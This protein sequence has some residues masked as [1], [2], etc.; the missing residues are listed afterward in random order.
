MPDLV[1]LGINERNKYEIILFVLI[2]LYLYDTDNVYDDL[3]III[4]RLLYPNGY[5]N[6]TTRE[7]L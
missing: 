1:R 6:V 4:L 3:V 5:G 7:A 2:S